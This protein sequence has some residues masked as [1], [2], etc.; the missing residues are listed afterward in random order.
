MDKKKKITLYIVLIILS[1]TMFL[2]ILFFN[3]DGIIGFIMF[4]FSTYLLVT[5]IIKLYKT[6]QKFKNSVLAFLDILLFWQH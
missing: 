1:I 6:S 4:L 5:S 3:I 2:S